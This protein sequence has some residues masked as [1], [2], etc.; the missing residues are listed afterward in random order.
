MKRLLALKA[1]LT[2]YTFDILHHPINGYRAVKMGFSWPALFFSVVWAL[3]KRM[4]SLAF[5]FVVVL[6][7]LRTLALMFHLEGMETAQAF[8][9]LLTIAFLFYIG[10]K[11]NHWHKNDLIRH[12]YDYVTRCEAV[13]PRAAIRRFVNEQQGAR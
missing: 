2:M 10:S 1:A 3:L 11:A 5:I 6:L 12:G 7:L 8:V 13:S 9:D 4:W